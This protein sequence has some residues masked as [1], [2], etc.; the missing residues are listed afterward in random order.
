[1]EKHKLKKME[2]RLLDNSF[3]LVEVFEKDNS[4]IFCSFFLC[5]CD[6]SRR[7]KERRLFGLIEI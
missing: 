2:K 6:Q 7:E 4:V 5:A 3:F 1:M